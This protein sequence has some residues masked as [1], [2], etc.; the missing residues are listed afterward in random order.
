MMPPNNESV[1]QI[2]KEEGIT[3]VTLY[4]WRKKARAAGVATEQEKSFQNL[5]KKELNYIK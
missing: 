5:E 1:M 2:E 3:E 4:K